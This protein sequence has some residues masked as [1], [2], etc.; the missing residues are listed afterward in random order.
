MVYTVDLIKSIKYY[1]L[2]IF[3]V[4]NINNKFIIFLYLRKSHIKCHISHYETSYTNTCAKWLWWTSSTKCIIMSF[5]RTWETILW[6]TRWTGSFG[7]S[8]YLIHCSSGHWKALED[9]PSCPSH[10]TVLLLLAS[11]KRDLTYSIHTTLFLSISQEQVEH[12]E[13]YRAYTCSRSA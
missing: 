11:F 6:K 12:L 1:E 13:N 7:H 9:S 10:C 5:P 3:F 4:I 2:K 8:S